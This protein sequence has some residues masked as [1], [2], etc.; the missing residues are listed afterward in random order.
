MADE[1]GQCTGFS[2]RWRRPRLSRRGL[3]SGGSRRRSLGRWLDHS[4]ARAERPG[5]CA[6]GARASAPRCRGSSSLRSLAAWPCSLATQYTLIRNSR[7]RRGQEQIWRFAGVGYIAGA[8]E[9]GHFETWCCYLARA[10]E[11]ANGVLSNPH[12]VRQAKPNFPFSVCL[13]TL[14]RMG[15]QVPVDHHSAS[16]EPIQYFRQYAL[17]DG[18]VVLA[19]AD[20]GE[21]VAVLGR[22]LGPTGTGR[23]RR[24]VTISAVAGDGA[25]RNAMSLH[26]IA[27]AL[28]E[29]IRRNHNAKSLDAL[30]HPILSKDARR[31]ALDALAATKCLDWVTFG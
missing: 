14:S 16:H 1:M 5:S 9:F 26:L 25:Y 6:Q 12:R 10:T 22:I 7:F 24:R 20:N 2:R 11:A 3:G 17:A 31:G 28:A 21:Q 29:A 8:K 30:F 23:V 18:V 15:L 27:H 4:A 13:W 19:D